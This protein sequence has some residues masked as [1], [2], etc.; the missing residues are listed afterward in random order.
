MSI[1]PAFHLS[2]NAARQRPE[3]AAARGIDVETLGQEGEVSDIALYVFRGGWGRIEGRR[4]STERG[5]LVWLTFPRSHAFN[6]LV[7]V[8]DF[9][10]ARRIEQMFQELGGERRDATEFFEP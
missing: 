5:G 9:R 7:W 10:L 6:P 3:I 2:A 4:R 1:G 8:F